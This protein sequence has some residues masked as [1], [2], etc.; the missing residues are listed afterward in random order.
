[1]SDAGK[2]VEQSPG[3][4]VDKIAQLSSGAD[5]KCPYING[6]MMVFTSDREGGFG[7]F[8]LWFSFYDGGGW[9]A[10]ENFGATINSEYDEYR[11]V[12]VSTVENG[13]LTDMMIFSSDRPGGKGLFD[14]YYVGIT[15]AKQSN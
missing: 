15:R 11:P 9:S 2:P 6:N 14:L 12:V 7:G 8:D 5:D 3:L 10:P 1:V 13:F 4:T